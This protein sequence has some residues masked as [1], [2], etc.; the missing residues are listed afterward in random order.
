MLVDDEVGFDAGSGH[1]FEGFGGGVMRSEWSSS[2]EG[3]V[4]VFDL[5]GFVSFSSGILA[6]FEILFADVCS[7]DC[8]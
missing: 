1:A 8:D 2:S 3:K 4:N 7:V 5:V 6:D